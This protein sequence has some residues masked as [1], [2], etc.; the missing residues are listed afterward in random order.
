MVV[1]NKT[2]VMKINYKIK[3]A[4]VGALMGISLL[5]GCKI[6]GEDLHLNPIPQ[7]D[8]DAVDLGEG[9]VRLINTTG[10]PSIAQWTVASSGQKFSGDTVEA[11]LI[12]AG[13]YD[14]ELSIVAQGGM[15]SVT[16]AV[17]ISENDPQACSDDRALGFIAGCDTKTWKL[18]PEAGAF[19][20]GPG[21]GNGE[22]W[23]SGAGDIQGRSCEFNDEFTFSFNAEGTFDYD[24][25]G[26]F[27]ADGYLGNQTAGCEP[28][29]N[30]TGEQKLWDSGTFS[31]VVTEGT[32]VNKLGQLRLV[33]KGA[34]IGVKKA[35]N[36][37]ETP[38]GPVNDY[39]LYDILSMEKNVDGKGYDLLTIGVNIGGDGWWSFTLRSY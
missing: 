19:K 11:N 16:K 17:S 14:V 5:Q 21:P 7:P 35:H 22:W 29:T 3:Y 37:G 31:F 32:G 27:F 33:G 26:D 8:F 39:V 38:T 28:A 30:L 18:N 1:Q 36:G 25:K 34:H 20:V 9:K 15:S 10:T 24:N 12:F 23:A 2:N 13:N 6:E 4:F